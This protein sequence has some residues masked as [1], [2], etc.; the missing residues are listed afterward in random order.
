MDVLLML[1][2]RCMNERSRWQTIIRRRICKAVALMCYACHLLRRTL[3]SSV[4]P[5]FDGCCKVDALETSSM[6][7]P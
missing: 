4:L 6:P 3:I 5:S 1:H 2:A 7:S